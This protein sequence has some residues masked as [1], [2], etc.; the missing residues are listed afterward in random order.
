MPVHISGTEGY[1]DEAEDLVKRWQKISFEEHHQPIQG[2]IPNVP[3]RVLDIGSGIGTDAA[4]LAAMGHQVV[5]VE[6]TKELRIPG[7]ALHAS[8]DIEWID[9]SLPDL[10]ILCDR[11]DTFDLILVTAV[12]MHLDELQRGRA[13]PKVASLLSATGVLV[14]SLRH[15]PVP[16]GRRMFDVSG[17]ETIHLAAK[18]GLSPVLHLHAQSVQ[19]ENL[20]SNV[21][22]TRLAFRRASARY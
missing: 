14:V 22:W 18:Q 20:L 3:S 9:D 12:W 15:G 1:A 11:N 21:S 13:M 16:P 4:A 7:I 2:L 19:A 5:A 10:G 17:A 8:S 6:P